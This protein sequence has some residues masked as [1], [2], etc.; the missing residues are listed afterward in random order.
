[1]ANDNLVKEAIKMGG[2]VS[3]FSGQIMF[4][5]ILDEDTGEFSVVVF[6]WNNSTDIKEIYK[7]AKKWGLVGFTDVINLKMAQVDAQ[8]NG[9]GS[10]PPACPFHGATMLASSKAGTYY[11]PRKLIDGT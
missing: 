4:K 2:Q 1:M 9:R 6:N 5:R 8:L 11:C 3:P 10:V 7:A